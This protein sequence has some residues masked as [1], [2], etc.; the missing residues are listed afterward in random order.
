MTFRLLPKIYNLGV[1]VGMFNFAITVGLKF[2]KYIINI[3]VYCY[4][5]LSI[6]IPDYNFGFY[7]S[8]I[9]RN[10]FIGSNF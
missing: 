7:F 10:N 5:L 2:S 8:F 9:I 1:P 3:K 4:G 6:F